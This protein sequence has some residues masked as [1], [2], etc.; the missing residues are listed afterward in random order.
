[1]SLTN[2]YIDGFNLYYLAVR[3]T[4]YKWLDPA[5]LCHCFCPASR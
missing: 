3:G 5:K 1:M 2:I 4:A